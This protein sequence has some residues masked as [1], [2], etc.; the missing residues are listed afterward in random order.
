MPLPACRR[1][2]LKKNFSNQNISN[3]SE[4]SGKHRG[5]PSSLCFKIDHLVSRTSSGLAHAP[6]KER[7]QAP[8]LAVND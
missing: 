8:T 2:I 5:F 7:Y 1:R 4:L 6:G 3:H